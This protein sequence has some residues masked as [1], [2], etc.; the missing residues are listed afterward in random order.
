ML[1]DVV[2]RSTPLCSWPVYLE[3]QLEP[4]RHGLGALSII[5][6]GKVNR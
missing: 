6:F 4:A 2:W 1:S 3:S 5:N